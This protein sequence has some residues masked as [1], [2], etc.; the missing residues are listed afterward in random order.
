MPVIPGSPSVASYNTLRSYPEYAFHHIPPQMQKSISQGGSTASL[1]SSTTTVASCNQVCHSDTTDIILTSD[2]HG[3][4]FALEIRSTFMSAV[5]SLVPVIGNLDPDGPADRSGVIQVGDRVIGVNGRST[6]GKSLEQ[7]TQEIIMSKPDVVLTIV[8]DVAESVI[9][10]SGTFIVKLAKCR[11]GLG[12]TIASPKNRLTGPLVISDVKK[13]S[14]AHRT[15]TIFAGDRLVAVNSIRTENCTVEEAAHILLSSYDVV[16]L[17]IQKDETGN[18]SSDLHGMVVYAVELVRHGGQLGLT[19]SGTEDGLDPI[20]IS[21]LTTGGLAERTGALQV[22]DNLLAINGQSLNGKPLSEAI[23]VLN[24]CGDAVTIKISRKPSCSTLTSKRHLNAM[25]QKSGNDDKWMNQASSSSQSS[26]TGTADLDS[27]EDKEWAKILDE[28]EE[29]SRQLSVRCTSDDTASVDS[30][31]VQFPSGISNLDAAAQKGATTQVKYLFPV[32][33]HR[34]TLFK[35]KCY[36]DFGFSVSDGLYEHG[37]YINRI[38]PGGPADVCSVI[39]PCDRILQVNS[40]RTHSY[41]CCHMVPL[42]ASSGDKI[43]LV[44]ARNPYT[45]HPKLHGSDI[46]LPWIEDDHDDCYSSFLSA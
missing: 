34:V 17:Q 18:G 35:D 8:F 26:C 2:M 40:T 41:D 44:I 38:R 19:I 24:N 46:G 7:V 23:A 13:G 29:C 42:I 32:E 43:Q 4:G 21:G 30:A 5:I 27:P 28:F 12:I 15:G 39:Q 22:G 9:P 36:E 6:N 31:S 37:V 25:P 1:T 10:S 45:S 33:L 14:V 11:G 3:F 20:V 16:K